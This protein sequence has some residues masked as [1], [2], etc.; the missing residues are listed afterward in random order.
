MNRPKAT[1][2]R[3][4]ML[5]REVT[6][7]TLVELIVAI[8]T[9]AILVALLLPTVSGM[10]ESSRRTA[11]S[12]NLRQIGAAIIVYVAE[13]DGSLPMYAP[14][15]DSEMSEHWMGKLVP[16]LDGEQKEGAQIKFVGAN[17]MRCPSADKELVFTYGV[18][19]TGLW[20]IPIISYGGS[21]P[22]SAKVGSLTANTMLVMD[23]VEPFVYNPINWTLDNETG[24]GYPGLG[25]DYNCADFKRHGMRIN[26]VFADGSVRL[27]PLEA[28]K[29]NQD[30]MWGF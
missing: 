24:D 25:D 19:Y 23:A 14:T 20:P 26:S 7:F 18:N 5:W 8:A 11:C 1:V 10:M 3:T 21:Y 15:L 4:A 27:V 17:F 28:W 29:K 2:R 12:N 16:Y 30:R 6:A 13:H 22:G 9:I